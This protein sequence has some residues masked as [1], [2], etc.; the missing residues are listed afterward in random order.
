MLVPIIFLHTAF[1]CGN[2]CFG[3]CLLWS[4]HLSLHHLYRGGW[5]QIPCAILCKVCLGGSTPSLTCPICAVLGGTL[6]T[7]DSMDSDSLETRLGIGW[8]GYSVLDFWQCLSEVVM[9]C[10]QPSTSGRRMITKWGGQE[11]TQR[12]PAPHGFRGFQQHPA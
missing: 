11:S 1:S 7:S 12:T 4:T 8:S 2:G 10:H 5:Q 6:P 9:A 3:L